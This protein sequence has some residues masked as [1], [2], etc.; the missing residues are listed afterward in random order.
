MF[1]L[2]ANKNNLFNFCVFNLWDLRLDVFTVKHVN[3]SNWS[4]VHVNGENFL[5]KFSIIIYATRLWW[6]GLW[7]KIV[8][9]R[10]SHRYVAATVNSRRV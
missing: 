1:F 2:K 8:H 3:I 7:L 10:V 9:T 6:R 4:L 5:G